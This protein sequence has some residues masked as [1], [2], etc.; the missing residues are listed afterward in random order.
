LQ[1][2]F[3]FLLPGT[4]RLKDGC[5]QDCL[6]PQE[7]AADAASWEF[8]SSEIVRRTGSM[9]LGF[10]SLRKNWVCFAKSLY[11]S[12]ALATAKG[13]RVPF[14]SSWPVGTITM[15]SREAMRGKAARGQRAV[16][17]G[18]TKFSW[19]VIAGGQFQ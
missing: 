6:A 11:V 5:S 19:I 8:G 9:C 12:F 10:L 1:N 15:N 3:K 13:C 17:S 4:R 18:P 7:R 2:H 14:H 16:Y